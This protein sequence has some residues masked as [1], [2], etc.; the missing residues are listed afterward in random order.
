MKGERKTM[1]VETDSKQADV[2][3]TLAVMSFY[4]QER[5]ATHRYTILVG[6]HSLKNTRL[7]SHE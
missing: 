6:T 3:F 5:A 7:V 4:V 1:L 2:I